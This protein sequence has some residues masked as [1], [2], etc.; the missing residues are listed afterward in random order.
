MTRHALVFDCGDTLLTLSPTRE[1][2]CQE[3]LAQLGVDVDLDRIA[4][5]YR[6][7]DFRLV[8]RSSQLKTSAEKRRFHTQYNTLLAEALG[9]DTRA[10]QLDVTLYD[11]FTA[12]RRWISFPGTAEAL[13]ALSPR[14]DL[15]VLANWDERLLSLLEDN[16]LAHLF[17]GIYSSAALGA[18]KPD[19]AIF[20]RFI[21]A[22]GV[23][24]AQTLYIGNEYRA[25]VMG[26][27]A[28]GFTPI[29]FDRTGHWAPH[30]DC[31]LVTD[32]SEL[33]LK[34]AAP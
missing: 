15:Y 1:Q 13:A 18:E 11:R 7:V 30:A 14:F 25:D 10:A 19:P 27:R 28:A 31:A 5:A 33:S 24:P 29:L 9:L 2:I 26:S 3:A 4:R 8:Q 21:A 16:Q 6:M 22:T 34:V 32:W 17:K 12:R 23:I 20:E